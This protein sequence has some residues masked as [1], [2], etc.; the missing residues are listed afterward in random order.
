MSENE[1]KRSRNNN[2]YTW[3]EQNYTQHRFLSEQ[4]KNWHKSQQPESWQQSSVSSPGFTT[5]IMY[6]GVNQRRQFQ[7]QPHLVT[8]QFSNLQT[9]SSLQ[10]GSS[11]SNSQR[12]VAN[13]SKTVLNQNMSEKRKRES[14]VKINED[15]QIEKRIKVLKLEESS[16]EVL[17]KYVP[18]EKVLPYFDGKHKIVGL[19]SASD[20]DKKTLQK[21][22]Q[23]I[24][25]LKKSEREKQRRIQVNENLFKLAASI[26]INPHL[27]DTNSILESATKYI[28]DMKQKIQIL[29]HTVYNSQP[30]L[31]NYI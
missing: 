16:L 14:I 3:E 31:H 21:I 1:R 17:Y 30:R 8:Q 13:E 28:E 11:F 26:G 15:E 6:S 23:A 20:K 27:H 9:S 29:E 24:R 7:Q 12:N 2:P 4:H 22:K 5:P 19:S 18:R 25:G 10:F